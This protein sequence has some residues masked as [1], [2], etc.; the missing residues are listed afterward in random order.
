MET[1]APVPLGP[2]ESMSP[3][4]WNPTSLVPSLIVPTL[5]I[6]QFCAA[7][8]LCCGLGIVLGP[9]GYL[10]GRWSAER[11]A[12]SGGALRGA[13]LAT[14]G[15]ISGIVVTVIWAL[16]LAFYIVQIAMRV[17]TSR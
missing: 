17:S 15:R 5:P 4:V 12:T 3:G 10:L 14:A 8:G 7:I 9:V 11:I 1:A 13:G 6:S 2:D 16:V